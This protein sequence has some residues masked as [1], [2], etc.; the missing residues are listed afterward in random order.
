MSKSIYLTVILFS[1]ISCNKPKEEYFSITENNRK[2]DSIYKEMI[3]QGFVAEFDI[4]QLL[5]YNYSMGSIHFLIYDSVDSYYRINNLNNTLLFCGNNNEFIE[6]DLRNDSIEFSNK[7]QEI[8]QIKTSQIIEILEKYQ[9]IIVSK[10]NNPAKRISFA[11]RND[12]LKGATIRNITEF[13][14]ERNMN[15]YFFRRM[16]DIEL[17]K[18]QLQK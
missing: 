16:N 11:L 8:K 17:K 15:S 4:N 2:M 3:E 6:E 7:I 9:D 13:M 10:D 1:I 5:N 18:T 14:S 12:T